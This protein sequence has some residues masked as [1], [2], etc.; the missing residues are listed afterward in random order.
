MADP[1]K[2]EP[3]KKTAA[4]QAEAD[5]R[6]FDVAKSAFTAYVSRHGGF[7]DRQAMEDYSRM[8]WEYADVFLAMEHAGPRRPEP[9]AAPTRERRPAR[10]AHPSDEWAVHDGTFSKRGF[11]SYEEAEFYASARPGAQIVQVGGPEVD[12]RQLASA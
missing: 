6:R 10:R 7:N 5:P 1:A 4:A 12:A 9:A 3:E 8:C 11:T 2:K